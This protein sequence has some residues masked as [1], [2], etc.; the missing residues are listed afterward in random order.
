MPTIRTACV[1]FPC[2]TTSR[3]CAAD[4]SFIKTNGDNRA[5]KPRLSLLAV[6]AASLIAGAARADLT[7]GVSLPLPGP[8]S[9]LGPPMPN[10]FKLSPTRVAGQNRNLLLLDAAPDPPNG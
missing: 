10:Q 6:L 3:P 1:P 9:A 8:A 4:R 2:P 7:V 5:M